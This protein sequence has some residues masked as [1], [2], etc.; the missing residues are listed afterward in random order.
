MEDA[1]SGLLLTNS[2]NI[3]WEKIRKID[4]RMILPALIGLTAM[5]VVLILTLDFAAAA[6]V[7]ALFVAMMFF[8]KSFSRGWLFFLGAA[9][10]FPSIGIGIG[11]VQL[12]DVFLVI[13]VIISL[14][15]LL[16]KDKKIATNRLAYSFFLLSLIGL[17]LA[18]FGTVF[19]E[20]VSDSVWHLL[21]NVVIFWFLLAAFQFFFQTRKRIRRFFYVL[22]VVGVV[23]SM[24][25]IITFLIGSPTSSGLGI[26]TGRT[27]NIISDEITTRATG[28]FGIGLENQLGA[29]PLPAFL[30]IT[31]LITAGLILVNYQREKDLLGSDFPEEFNR[32]QPLA[33]EGEGEAGVFNDQL[34]Q[35]YRKERT[36]YYGLFCIQLIGLFLTFSYSSYMFLG[37]GLFVIGVL[38][39]NRRVL[40]IATFAL[41]IFTVIIPLFTQNIGQE[42]VFSGWLEG[43]EKILKNPVIGSAL[44]SGAVAGEKK[45]VA[46]VG[47]SNSFLY[48]WNYFGIFGLAVLVYMLYQ[49]F[50]DIYWNFRETEK[51]ARIWYIV[52]L[53][54]FVVIV[55]EALTSNVLIIGPTAVIFWLLY[56]AV[57]NLRHKNVQFGLT[58]TKIE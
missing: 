4:H 16:L 27:Q 25:G 48:V 41:V 39:K 28:L 23:H 35:A 42:V 45:V 6:V 18:V 14:A 50:L 17:A 44:D 58:E 33:A 40:G 49:Y 19:G 31:I 30:L 46:G 10:V 21:L 51:A 53:S 2:M 43:A 11:R 5:A 36:F 34:Q 38:L 54:I 29:N 52:I 15:Q 13:L 37:I 1:Y 47:V 24:A 8:Y 56:G 3:D 22:V 32:K 20:G 9:M 55:L 12:F 57:V 7:G 26:S